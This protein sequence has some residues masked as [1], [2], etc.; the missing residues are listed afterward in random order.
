MPRSERPKTRVACLVLVAVLGVIAAVFG[1]AGRAGAATDTFTVVSAGYPTGQAAGDLTVVIDS[2]PT[3]SAVTASLYTLPAATTDALDAPLTLVGTPT[4]I[5][6]GETRSTW[7][8]TK[9]ITTLTLGA[10]YQINLLITFPDTT[11]ASPANVGTLNY[12]DQLK[13][14]AKADHTQVSY[15][16]PLVN[17]TGTVTSLNADGTTGPLVNSTIAMASSL[18]STISVPTDG[19]GA[20]SVT[21]L[22]PLGGDWVL[23]EPNAA[24]TVGPQTAPINFTL[25]KDAVQVTASLSAGTIVYGTKVSARG[26]VRYAPTAGTYVPF[27]KR[28]V[29]I[30]SSNNPYKP[31]TSAV[32]DSKGRFSVVLP[33][34]NA[35]TSWTFEAGGNADSNP[36]LGSATGSAVL[37]VNLPVA[38]TGFKISLNQFWQL[39]YS[40]CVTFARSV[41]GNQGLSGNLVF[42]YAESPN[43][44]WRQFNAGSQAGHGCGIKGYTFHAA[45]VSAPVN[46][47]Y[48]RAYFQGAKSPGIGSPGFT[49]AG[50]KPVLAWKYADRIT[51]F[52]V[53]PHVVAKNG[54]ITVTGQLQYYYNYKWHSY[55]GQV[56]YII[57]RQVNTSTW[58]WIVKVTTNSTGHFSA[59]FADV[60]GSASWSAQFNGNSRH[61]AASP[62]AVYVRVKG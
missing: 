30:Y 2:K 11:T 1:P 47:A 56:I 62:P 7:A 41:P 51:N 35:K 57:F 10:S 14:T 55:G 18:E 22:R 5:G 60:V 53:S 59:R 8:V 21:N 13:I 33:S 44:P 52:S 58:H 24:G 37:T 48:Y 39:T 25:H 4:D 20:F 32:T 42:Q 61:L 29:E 16:N 43:G 54:N 45:G 15:D 36:Y 26:V 27:Q 46:Y 38:V 49:S 6:N 31:A 12:D 23:F 19:S 40:G 28:K 50:S 34:V 9:P 17:V 3:I